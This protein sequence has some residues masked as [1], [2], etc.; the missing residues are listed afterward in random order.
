MRDHGI[1]EFMILFVGLR[2]E[3]QKLFGI[4]NLHTK[5]FIVFGKEF[6]TAIFSSENLAGAK[7]VELGI[8]VSDYGYC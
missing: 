5:L 8:W 3:V 1:D 2:K 6:Q 4:P 7:N